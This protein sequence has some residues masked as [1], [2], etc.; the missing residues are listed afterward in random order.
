MWKLRYNCSAAISL[1]CLDTRERAMRSVVVDY[2][3]ASQ[4]SKVQSP[5][6]AHGAARTYVFE[7][8]LL[9]L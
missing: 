4:F 6:E 9:R 7:D 8:V 3:I 2:Q 1:K 5:E